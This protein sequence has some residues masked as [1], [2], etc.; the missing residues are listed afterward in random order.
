[1][2]DMMN[3]RKL[4]EERKRE[5]TGVLGAAAHGMRAGSTLG[6]FA[7]AGGVAKWAADLLSVVAKQG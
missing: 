4:M 2:V 5:L 6:R 3:L 1:M 7:L